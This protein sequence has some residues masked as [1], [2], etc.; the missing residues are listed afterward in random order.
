MQH[1]IRV[2]RRKDTEFSELML[3]VEWC[4]HHIIWKY[5]VVPHN[6]QLV[7]SPNLH[8]LVTNVVMHYACG[9]VP[10]LQQ[11]FEREYSFWSKVSV[12]VKVLRWQWFLDLTFSVLL[13]NDVLAD[14]TL[15][16]TEW[17]IQMDTSSMGNRIVIGHLRKFS[18][19]RCKKSVDFIENQ[20]T[21]HF[22]NPYLVLFPH[23]I[24]Q[25]VS[26]CHIK[27]IWAKNVSLQKPTVIG[28]LIQLLDAFQAVIRHS[29]H[30]P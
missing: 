14:V 6:A 29:L 15:K 24:S 25:N 23:R 3:C 26:Q 18:Y 1:V 5:V 28:H 30:S 16:G 12:K 21:I 27:F 10:L 2:I 19:M 22:W 4:R 9:H 17:F 7:L 20:I 8:A 11:P 13:R